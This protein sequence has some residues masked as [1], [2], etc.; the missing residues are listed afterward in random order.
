MGCF[1]LP[2]WVE[3]IFPRR[4]P[5][6]LFLFRWVWVWVLCK[7]TVEGRGEGAVNAWMDYAAGGGGGWLRGV[8]LDLRGRGGE[9]RVGV[10]GGGDGG[11]GSRTYRAGRRWE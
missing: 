2:R 9:G 1:D 11:C 5:L 3:S 4:F 10:L 7:K 8:H 6:F